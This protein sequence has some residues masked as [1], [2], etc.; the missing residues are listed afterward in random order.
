MKRIKVNNY[1]EAQNS[2]CQKCGKDA[3]LRPYGPNGEWICYEC[4]MKDEVTTAKM[5]AKTLNPSGI[6]IIDARGDNKDGDVYTFHRADGFYPLIFRSDEEAVANAKCNPDTLKVV[7]EITH[8][9]VFK[10]EP[11]A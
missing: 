5:Y 11:G 9:V 2:P 10:K 6:T 4:G 7:N 8:K 1:R 3:E